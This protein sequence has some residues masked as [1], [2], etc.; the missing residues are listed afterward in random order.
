MSVSVTEANK[1]PA[2]API[3]A[4]FADAVHDSQSVFNDVMHAMARP[5]SIRA[6]KPDLSPPA[7]LTPCSAAVLL[8]LADYDTTVWLDAVTEADGD[9]LRWLRFHTGTKT[10]Q[11]TEQAQFAIVT[12]PT[13]L[14]NLSH[15]APGTPLYPDRSTT[16][17]VQ[18]PDLQPGS[19]WTLSGPGIAETAQLAVPS[20]PNWFVDQWTA[21]RAR[22]PLGVDLIF[23]APDRLACLPRT[24]AIE[25][26]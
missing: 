26:G 11:D 9:T 16:I 21:N 3:A 22:F 19:G 4:G 23:C 18:V 10:A 14:P 7:V 17:I 13:T 12:A 15:F 5:G 20:L 2:N 1:M 8:A 6:I 24:T 25:E